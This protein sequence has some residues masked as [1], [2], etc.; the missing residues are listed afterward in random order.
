MPVKHVKLF[1]PNDIILLL[2]N[3][4]HEKNFTESK[5][6]INFDSVCYL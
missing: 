5:D 1:W 4:L 2:I 6:K 3:N